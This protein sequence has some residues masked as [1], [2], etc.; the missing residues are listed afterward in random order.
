MKKHLQNIEDCLETLFDIDA[1]GSFL[2]KPDDKPIMSSIAR[3]VSRSIPLTDRQHLL[4]KRKLCNYSDYFALHGIEN[5]DNAIEQTRQPL[6]VVDRSKTIK[7]AELPAEVYP[8]HQ[9][10]SGPWIEISFPFNKKTINTI[11]HLQSK[12]RNGYQH[13]SGYREHYF[14]FNDLNC[15]TIV[16]ELINR[17]FKIEP[18]LVEHYNKCKEIVDNADKY[19]PALTPSGFQ[20][21]HEG[22]I[23]EMQKHIGEFSKE[24]FHAFY[25][26]RQ[27]Y[28][29]SVDPDIQVDDPL[30]EMILK[31]DK[32]IVQVKPSEHKL[33]DLFNT[34]STLKRFPVLAV[35]EEL[36]D[37]EMIHQAA[38]NVVPNDQQVVFFRLPNGNSVNPFN[39]YIH[40]NGLNNK[41]DNNTKIVYINERKLQK[42]LLN[43]DWKP[44]ACLRPR[45]RYV[46]AHSS[47]G[48][49]VNYYCDLTVYY[50]ESAS[51]FMKAF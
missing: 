27:K 11:R 4:L 43:A 51:P 47:V 24:N 44:V 41:L 32:N 7:L 28:G 40:D 17:N 23:S 6:R 50:E 38:S 19:V 9:N 37:L 45:S 39:Q 13:K 35:I 48:I 1:N 42:P 25:D 30:L 14:E 31:R 5:F 8:T 3:Q 2:L 12:C 33:S 26:R 36:N 16:H 21:L 49:Y 15:Y 10:Q 22:A 29:F 46:S 18:F 34:L 20:N